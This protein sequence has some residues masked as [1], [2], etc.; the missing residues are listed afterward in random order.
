M[1]WFTSGV[2]NSQALIL[3]GTV[4]ESTTVL[5]D[6]SGSHISSSTMYKWRV[7]IL[8]SCWN[9]IQ[10]THTQIEQQQKQHGI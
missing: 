9:S 8:L 6:A 3:Q 2:T 4:S 1:Y 5:R 7:T 10:H